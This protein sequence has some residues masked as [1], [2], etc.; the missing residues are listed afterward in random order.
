MD[1]S[2]IGSAWIPIAITIV[3]FIA[4]IGL[5]VL[6]IVRFAQER[7]KQKDLESRPSGH[8]VFAKITEPVAPMHRGDKYE[9]PLDQDLRAQGLGRVT[10]GG[11]QMDKEGAIAW[12]GIDIELTDL[13]RGIEFTRRRLHELGAPSGSV[14]EYRVG[15]Q[16]MTVAIS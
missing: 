4:F 11:T 5:I 10:G 14:L 1:N 13:D 9:E 7:R 12:V 16:K 3:A 6:G 8:F 2:S 15:E